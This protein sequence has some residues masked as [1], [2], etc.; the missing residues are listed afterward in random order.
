MH[1][2]CAHD[3]VVVLFSLRLLPCIQRGREGLATP[4]LSPRTL[5]QHGSLS[6]MANLSAATLVLASFTAITLHE[7]VLRRV[8]VDHLVLPILALNSTVYMGL[9]YFTGFFEATLLYLTFWSTLWIYIGAYRTLFHPLR[10]YPGPLYARLS[11]W[12]TVKKTID[13]RWHWYRVQQELQI[14][15]GDYVRT[16]P[17]ELSIFDP[18]AAQAILGPQSK[19]SKGP[20]YDVMEKS[21]HLNRDKTWHRQRRRIW[22]N[23]MKTS[24]SGFALQIEETCDQLI[25]RL[26]QANGKPLL[27]L[28]T[29]TYFS[30]DVTSVLAFGKAMG[31]TT[32]ESS[33]A[34]DSILST[35]TQSLSAMGIMY[36]MPW[37]MN[38]LT[39]LTSLAGPLKDW[40][41]W[42]VSQME[43][44]MAVSSECRPACNDTYRFRFTTR[45]LI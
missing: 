23:A 7:I 1:I 41:D 19:T 15:Y 12:Y 6:D 21:L 38:A 22:D 8:E 3:L 11:K 5:F 24:L 2:S 18:E 4:P 39:I 31:F 29:M 33:K 37:L 17:R 27:L 9:A 16:G 10:H 40:T 20:F 42:S 34:A 32:G 44:R 35:F 45:L 13:T 26:R 36:H 25:E 30:Y 43:A 28:E 14:Q